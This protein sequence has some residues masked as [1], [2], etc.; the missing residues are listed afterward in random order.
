[1]T[2]PAK[3]NVVQ[4][5]AFQFSADPIY[6]AADTAAPG[7]LVGYRLTG[8]RRTKHIVSIDPATGQPDAH[9]LA[10]LHLWI[11][12]VNYVPGSTRKEARQ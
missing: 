5:G 11:E 10:S 4:F 9:A 1:M 7:Q 12:Y 8:P 6:T 2:T 3:K